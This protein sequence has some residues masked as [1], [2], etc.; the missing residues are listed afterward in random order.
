MTALLLLAATLSALANEYRFGLFVG[1]NGGQPGDPELVFAEADASKM[2]DLFVEYGQMDARD[3]VLLHGATARQVQSEIDKLSARIQAVVDDGHEA[4]FVF[5]YSGH[6]DEGSLHLGTTKIE[7][8]NLRTWIDRTGAQ[9]RVA[10]VDACQSGGLVRRKGGARGPAM[11][12]ALPSVEAAHG[13]AIITSSAAS[14][15]SQESTEIGG[16]FFTH[17]LHT[18]LTG[19]ADRDRDGEVS[20]HEAYDYVHSETAFRTRE[21]PETQ[22]PNFDFD[23]SGSG[24]LMLTTL[25]EASAHLSF[26]GDLEGAYSVWDQSR[27]RYVAEVEG[28]A[29]MTLA[30]RP[31]TFYVH[32]RMP[33]WVEEASYVVRRGET[34]SVL[35]ED[36]TVVSYASVASRGDIEKLIRRSKIPDLSLRFVMGFRNFGDRGFAG[37][38]VP[39]HAIGGVEARFLGSGRNYWGFDVLTGGGSP[40]LELDGLAPVRSVQTTTSLAGVI[41]FA[42]RPGLMRAGIGGRSAI[43]VITRDFPDWDLEAQ[44]SGILGAGFNAWGGIHHGRFTGDLQ[45]NWLLLLTRWDDNRGWPAYRDLL[46]VLGYRF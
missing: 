3:A 9:A 43:T 35:G 28:G 26:L 30:V 32:K 36:F 27:K 1:N 5:Y 8:V 45:L 14:E 16:G 44:S 46:L 19:G 42:T 23:M 13:T 17:Y 6:G 2:R 40:V 21:A 22:T 4:V 7:H 38:Y 34:R 25:E 31:G 10:M 20:L 12:F 18:A 24:S 41:G 15:L 37:A 29:P 11:T 39:A 33:G